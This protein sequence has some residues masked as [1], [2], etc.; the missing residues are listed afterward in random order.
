MGILEGFENKSIEELNKWV[1]RFGQFRLNYGYDIHRVTKN[2]KSFRV[3]FGYNRGKCGDI[4]LPCH[5][6]DRK[7]YL[8]YERD[9][10]G[11]GCGL[12]TY[13]T[14]TIYLE[15]CGK[16][17]KKTLFSVFVPCEEDI[18]SC[19]TKLKQEAMRN[20]DLIAA[21]LEELVQQKRPITRRPELDEDS[22]RLTAKYKEFKI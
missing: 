3:L 9:D 8:S 17:S 20:A 6:H 2:G 19:L 12:W 21:E 14:P 10:Y 4:L 7:L 16:A 5:F 22:V 18:I 15:D 1:E 11:E 13:Y